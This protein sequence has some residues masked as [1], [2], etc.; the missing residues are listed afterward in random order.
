MLIVMI[1]NI[2][3]VGVSVSNI[4]MNIKFGTKIRYSLW[5]QG[6]HLLVT[7]YEPATGK[8]VGV[9][10]KNSERIKSFIIDDD[11]AFEKV[12]GKLIFFSE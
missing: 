1:P 9:L 4:L 7:E 3:N 6:V 10:Y 12:F 11:L 2:F 5:P 8:V